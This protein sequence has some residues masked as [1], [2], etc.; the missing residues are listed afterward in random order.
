V[1]ALPRRVGDETA[2]DCFHRFG[3]QLRTSLIKD[4]YYYYISY[5][6]LKSELKSR[7]YP[8][9]SSAPPKTWTEE[10]EKAFV[11]VLEAELDK[12]FT[13]Q[14]VK[15]GEI[16]RR[17]KVSQKEVEDVIKLLDSRRPGQ[18]PPTEEDFE[19]LE[20][21]LSDIIADVHDLAKFTQLNYTGF[22]KIIKKHDVG[23]SFALFCCGGADG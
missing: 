22:Q 9:G 4:Y 18:E 2:D 5:D 1:A 19:M 10:D 11:Q 14:K 17:I 16:V 6:D 13:F 21:D 12:V 15:S 8:H 7:L 23:F 20:E 3:Q